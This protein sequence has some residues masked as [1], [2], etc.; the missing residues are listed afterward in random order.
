MWRVVCVLSVL[1]VVVCVVVVVACVVSP[2]V[3]ATRANVET[4]VRV[5]PACTGTFWIETRRA[6]WTYTRSPS[7]SQHTDTHTNTT[8]RQTERA[9][10]RYRKEDERGER[11][12]DERRGRRKRERRKKKQRSHVHQRWHLKHLGQAQKHEI[13]VESQRL[14]TAQIME[15][16]CSRLRLLVRKWPKQWHD[17]SNHSLHLIKLF[18]SSSPER[19]SGGNQLWD[20]SV[21]LSPVSPSMTID[22][23]VSIATPP[24]FPMTL[25]FWSSVHHM[26]GLDKDEK[27]THNTHTYT[28]LCSFT[29]VYTSIHW[30]MHVIMNRHGHNHIRNG[31]VWVQTGHSTCTCT[32]T[33]CDWTLNTPKIR[34]V[35]KT[36]TAATKFEFESANYSKTTRNRSN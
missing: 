15:R 10:E 14:W 1:C 35:Q 32:A 33:V 31:I 23:H 28:Y 13:I 20:G 36:L 4:H 21:C 22:L 18:N 8:R 25:R 3:L 27:H 24:R 19:H 29:Y 17:S 2:C 12:D 34:N 26:S 7:L 16:T 6:F 30:D 11:R 9:R 5:L